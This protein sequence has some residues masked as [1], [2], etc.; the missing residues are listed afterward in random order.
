[1][2][3]GDII[4]HPSRGSLF[5]IEEVWK[6]GAVLHVLRKSGD[7]MDLCP[8]SKPDFKSWEEIRKAGMIV[9]VKSR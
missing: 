1:M 9:R 2:K 7:G 3:A 8:H 5:R 6:Y 4:G